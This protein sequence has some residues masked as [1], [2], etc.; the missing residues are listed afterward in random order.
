MPHSA[1]WKPSFPDHF[2]CPSTLYNW[3]YCLTWLISTPPHSHAFPHSRLVPSAEH[4]EPMAAPSDKLQPLF[5]TLSSLSR[6]N[7]FSC[8]LWMLLP[9]KS[10]QI[11]PS[12]SSPPLAPP[13]VRTSVLYT[14]LALHFLLKIFSP[15]RLLRKT[16]TIKPKHRFLENQTLS[17]CPSL[18]L[19]AE[20]CR[21]NPWTH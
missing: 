12:P 3:V 6:C 9:P 17:Y 4:N 16:K 18:L 21:P 7:W 10:H 1:C 20:T 2:P 8:P 11:N 15:P 5:W 19:S 13:C 14:L